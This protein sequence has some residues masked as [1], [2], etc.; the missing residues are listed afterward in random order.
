MKRSV[1]LAFAVV[2]TLIG[3]HSALRPVAAQDQM[4]DFTIGKFT[5]PTDP[6]TVSLAAGNIPD[7]CDPTAGVS[8][9]VALDDGTEIGSC[10]TDDSGICKVQVPN[11]AMVTA[12]ED[13]TTA[14]AGFAPRE[15]PISTQAVTEFAGAL[16]INLP[17]TQ[18][19]VVGVG[20]T[21]ERQSGSDSMLVL[22]ALLSLALAVTGIIWR[23]RVV[24]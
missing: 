12:T 13:T 11:E 15:N 9:T 18:P 2:V 7:E 14:P 10:T 17:V 24:R 21:A 16:F 20:T 8:F 3:L 5:C 1:L 23:R 19:P 22:T 4:I 6:G